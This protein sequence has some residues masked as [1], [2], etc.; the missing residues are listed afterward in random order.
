[1]A[2]R[3]SSCPWQRTK[4][5]RCAY[6]F[7]VCCTYLL[8]PLYLWTGP[9]RNPNSRSEGGEA[10]LT[11]KTRI[12]NSSVLYN[13]GSSS[14]CSL[15]SWSYKRLSIPRRPNIPVD[16]SGVFAQAAHLA[17]L[18]V[19]LLRSAA[20]V[21]VRGHLAG[22][23]PTR[24]ILAHFTPGSPYAPSD[25]PTRRPKVGYQGQE[26]SD[27]QYLQQRPIA[28]NVANRRRVSLKERRSKTN[29]AAVISRPVVP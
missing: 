27:F 20:K 11:F 16:K 7:T 10:G 21:L 29:S 4:P 28:A 17:A 1:M 24:P 22:L 12:R 19:R 13:G 3:R 15:S 2:H 14:S 6:L 25:P 18:P 5:P 26:N 9:A 23:A 8:Q